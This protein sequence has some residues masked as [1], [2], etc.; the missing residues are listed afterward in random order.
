MSSASNRSMRTALGRARGHGSGH[1]GTGHFIAQRVTAVALLLL[2][3]WLAVSAALTM[4]DAGYVAA[5]DFLT[6]P[7]NAVGIILFLIAVLYHM[8]IGMQ[9]IVEDY[10][11]SPFSKALLLVANTLL[12]FA[13]GAGAIFALLHV[14]FGA[15]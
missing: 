3:P 6:Q 2:A 4:P 14:N 8:S 15:F 9:V 12:A 7:L 13:L 5:I 11:H 10:V 1:G